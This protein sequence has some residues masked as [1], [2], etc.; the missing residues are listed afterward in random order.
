VSV[1]EKK[2]REL[3]TAILS[4]IVAEPISLTAILTSLA[5][6]A[7]T[8]AA[9]YLL[10]RALTPA[11]K[12]IEKGRT[13]GQLV[14]SS[15]LGTP[16]PEFFFGPGDDGY[17]GT[18]LPAIVVSLSPIAKTVN[19]TRQE[20]G[21]GKGGHQTQEVDEI[22]YYFP[23]LGLMYGKGPGR[24]LR[25]KANADVVYD[26]YGEVS[27]YE[28]EAGTLSG[29]TAFDTSDNYSG[30]IDV[31]LSLNASIQWATVRSNGAA[32]RQAQFQYRTADGVTVSA[33]LTV[34][35]SA[36]TISFPGSSGNYRSYT[37]P[38]SLND[39]LNTIKVK[40]L[41]ATHIL[42]IDYLYCFPGLAAGQTGILDPVVT[43]DDPYDPD[44][45]P[46]PTIPHVKPATRYNAVADMDEFGVQ[47]GTIL[48]GGNAQFAIYPGSDSQLPDPTIQAA[49]D[50]LY[51]ADSTPAYRG[52]L[53]EVDTNLY[54]T[55]WANAIPN[56]T[57]LFEHDVIRTLE[58]ACNH[59]TGRTNID[60]GDYDYS[61]FAAI[62]P[63]GLR[64]LQRYEAREPMN[65]AAQ[66]FNL[67]FV[68]E[69]F[70][71]KGKVRGDS[72]VATL[73]D[74]DFS[75]TEGEQPDNL[76]FVDVTEPK[77]ESQ[78]ASVETKYQDLD[79]EG[80]P[81][82]QRY[83][84][85]E[86]VG[87]ESETI[88]ITDWTLTADEA[89]ALAQ[90]I[91]Y[92]R[93][94]EK[95]VTFNISWEFLWLNVGQ[96]ITASLST[97]FTYEI[98]ITK[99]AGGVGV[100][101]CEGVLIDTPI[102]DQSAAANSSTFGTPAVPLPA[103]TILALL[104]IPVRDKDADLN[105]GLLLYIGGTPRTNTGQKWAGYAA[106]IFDVGWEKMAVGTLPATMGVI[107][108]LSIV[109]SNTSTIDTVSYLEFD[110]YHTDD[111]IPV[112]ESVSTT[113]LYNGANLLSVSTPDGDILVQF[114]TA[115]QVSPNKWRVTNLLHGRGGT[116]HLVG[117]YEVGRRV[118]LI[119]E[120]IQPVPLS[121]HRLNGAFD[122]TGVSNGQ[123]LDDAAV[124]PDYVWTGQSRKPLSIDANSV[125]SVRDTFGTLL[126]KFLGRARAG[127]GLRSNQAGA[128]GEE[129]EEYRAQILDSGATTL[130]SGDERIF[131]IKPGTPQPGLL[132]PW[133]DGTPFGETWY[134][135]NDVIGPY[136]VGFA[137]SG[138]AALAS[139]EDQA[140]KE[141]D[142][143]VE[144]ELIDL[145][146]GQGPI[147]LGLYTPS[148]FPPATFTGSIKYGFVYDPASANLFIYINGAP[149]KT[150]S[151]ATGLYV[152]NGHRLSIRVSETGVGFYVDYSPGSQS[153]YFDPA[154]P[155]LPLV[156]GAT[157]GY[158]D[159][160]NGIMVTP[161]S[162][163]PSFIYTDEMQIHDF[164]S[165]QDPIEVDIWQWS[166][167]VGDGAKLT[168]TL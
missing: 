112:L 25:L 47:T 150:L 17:G 83:G 110:L 159:R 53:I 77:P 102:F 14:I 68:E 38:V 22:T 117:S 106:Y 85:H 46:D 5:I 121:A 37:V 32:T 95:H 57:G 76:T 123:S 21:G 8:S 149:V 39:G 131:V 44:S 146:G 1:A 75:W 111:F 134:S 155:S 41:N 31:S 141:Y 63:R 158:K 15:Q 143:F 137:G 73:T 40:N 26:L 56:R 109:G 59:W 89:Q 2:R 166:S 72:S 4:K 42:A 61:E 133:I 58:Q 28:A 9:S 71:I 138:A 62:L 33:E 108:D 99:I 20:V 13:T 144:A 54:L 104:D 125:K 145:S 156:V 36:S 48:H 80:D 12:P 27:K 92:Q 114:Q 6:S 49:I 45:P 91:E 60:S 132:T 105:N 164:G 129:T 65:E 3:E 101:E 100:L 30:G 34:N 18:W 50:A 139:L 67:I 122:W 23:Y 148:V 94:V 97:G 90:R 93:Y 161:Q 64:K 160:M 69:E 84:R 19:V 70:Q 78:P 24:A 115:T 142:T 168:F 120:A 167:V 107:S 86:T 147:I 165:A 154:V 87:V 55:R 79:R 96:V 11:P 135:G 98:E 153:L 163:R 151:N 128:V 103:A 136:G 130:P 74:A 88:D 66:I 16:I 157:V 29:T 51:G 127:G 113:D 119:N 118:V 7:A 116:E 152:G 140:L 82:L 52:R 81:G 43:P 10:T 162:T 35:G 124:I 126:T